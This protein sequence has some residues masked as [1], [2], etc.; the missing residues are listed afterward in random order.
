LP[1]LES[2]ADESFWDACAPQ[3][4]T[5]RADPQDERHCPHCQSLVENDAIACPAC[6]WPITENAYSQA[7]KQ[8]GNPW[9]DRLVWGA[10]AFAAIN[11]WAALHAGLFG[12]EFGFSLFLFEAFLVG[13]PLS[14]NYSCNLLDVDFDWSDHWWLVAF[15]GPLS[16]L[17]VGLGLPVYL[18]AFAHMVEVNF[19]R[20]VL[21]HLLFLAL[22][23]AALFAVVLLSL[24]SL[25][26]FGVV[27]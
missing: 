6:H 24:P 5:S 17:P 11:I 16:I 18:L 9:R 15:G 26:A 25:I 7:D 4:S 14:F 8:E 10:V 19:L 2:G 3:N 12:A 1:P 21:V 23:P 13:L 20:A 27:G 22:L